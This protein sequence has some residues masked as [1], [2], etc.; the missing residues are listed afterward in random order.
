MDL[1]KIIRTVAGLLGLAG[2]IFLV[3]IISKGDEAIKA[4][5]AGGDTSSVDPMAMTAYVTLGIILFVVL[6]F[7]LQNLVTHTA[8]LKKTLVNIGAFLVLFLIAY[9]VFANGVE[10]PMRDGEMLSEGGSKLVGAGLYLFYFLIVIAA[11][12]MVFSGAGKIIKR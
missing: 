8:T 2:I 12:L 10:T 5:A 1:H 11:V 7:V 6:F 3:M 9:F 4:A